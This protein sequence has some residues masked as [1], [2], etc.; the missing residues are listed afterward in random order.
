MNDVLGYD[1]DGE[2]IE[3]FRILRFP[4][5]AYIENWE[6]EPGV[7]PR[8]YCPVRANDGKSYLIS[9]Y[10]DWFHEQ[11]RK[12]EKLGKSE[13][14]PIKIKSIEEAKHYEVAFNG[15]TKAEW[16]YDR[17]R[18]A[19]KEK[20][21]MLLKQGDAKIVREFK[22]PKARELF[23]A[24]LK[25]DEEADRMEEKEIAATGNSFGK[26]GSGEMHTEAAGLRV[27][28]DDLEDG[29]ISEEEISI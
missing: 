20:L 1:C 27:L 13:I 15:I 11:I 12:Y 16:Y 23:L 8:F 4:F 17:D 19:L 7:D 25:I 21:E 5:S 3:E 14:I 6:E 28:A 2:E 9:V 10:D 29:F 24:S 22:N 26:N 18:K